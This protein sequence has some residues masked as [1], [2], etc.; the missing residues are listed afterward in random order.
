[1]RLEPGPGRYVSTESVDQ[2]V[3]TT[4]SA[5]LRAAFGVGGPPRPRIGLLGGSF[6]PA[7]AGHLHI[8]RWA[9]RRLRLDEVW[10]LVSPQNPLKPQDG[11]ADLAARVARARATARDRRLRV[12]PLE[13]ML[14]TTYTVDTLVRLRRAFPGT[15]FVWLMGADNLRQIGRWQGW[16][17]IFHT[18]PIAVLDRPTYCLRATVGLAARRFARQRRAE[19]AAGSLVGTAPPAWVLLHGRRHMA[20][21]TAIRAGAP[22][23]RGGKAHT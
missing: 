5:M 20:S 8:S 10:W 22:M 3:P 6:N 1:M 9:L 18:V 15:R 2:R 4:R 12:G 17:R 11:M 19:R 7:H 16:T 23:A 13:A 14:G 21:A